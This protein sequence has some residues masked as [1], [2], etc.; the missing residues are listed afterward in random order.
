M[1]PRRTARLGVICGLGLGLSACALFPHSRP[2]LAFLPHPR[3]Q[4]HVRPIEPATPGPV[5]PAD[6]GLYRDAASAIAQRDYGRA[7][8]LLQ[9]AR[10]RD[11][12]DPRV[13]NA[14]GVV[15]DKLGRFDLSAEFYAEAE[16]LDPGS[17][18]VANNRA[19]S[20]MLQ[21]KSAPA[22]AL[23]AAAVPPAPPGSPPTLAAN[24]AGIRLAK[25]DG[26]GVK[27]VIASSDSL[28]PAVRRQPSWPGVV[29]WVG[30]D[31]KGEVRAANA[32]A[33]A[34]GRDACDHSGDT[35]W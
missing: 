31:Q 19:Y 29:T 35:S 26:P 28:P 14:F 12:R 10:D 24:G 18:I 23:A 30:S 15:Y 22:T 7:L 17:Q 16:S 2:W 6:E 9:A 25:T 33:D 1:N 34:H 32:C 8:D 27:A 3:P 4:V 11:P 13:P 21:G 5:M 20:L